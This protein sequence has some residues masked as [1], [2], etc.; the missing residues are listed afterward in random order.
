MTVGNQRK[1]S[2]TKLDDALWTY[3]TAF[4]LLLRTIPFHLL[5]GK[6]YHLPVE[7]EHKA[8]WIV[9]MTNFDIK[10]FAERRLIQLNELNDIRHHAYEKLSN[11]TTRYFCTTLAVRSY[12]AIFLLSSRGHEFTLNGQ[13][14][15]Y[16]WTKVEIPDRHIVQ[17]DEPPI[18]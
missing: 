11:S 5:C 8:A 18:D 13:R 2:S 16:Y 15:K 9:K 4:K 17:L 14:V 1:D 7:L 10:S 12:G 6:A 3:R